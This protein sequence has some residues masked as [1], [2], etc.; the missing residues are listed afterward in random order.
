MDFTMMLNTTCCEE[1]FSIILSEIWEEIKKIIVA[2]VTL[3]IVLF[4]MVI[5][6][7]RLAEEV[8]NV[9]IRATADD[10][11]QCLEPGTCLLISLC[12]RPLVRSIVVA[13]TAT[14]FWWVYFVTL[15][16]PVYSYFGMDWFIILVIRNL[17]AVTGKIV[18]G[19][20]SF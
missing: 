11:A 9:I 6:T 15:I 13:V 2:V 10:G 4:S 5:F 16:G 17:C 12:K 18:I 8:L 20:R 14:F 3:L 7:A 19:W 1:D